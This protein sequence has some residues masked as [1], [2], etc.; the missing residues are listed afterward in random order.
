MKKTDAVT[1]RKKY[2]WE[3]KQGRAS[4]NC[5]RCLGSENYPFNGLAFSRKINR[6]NS[7]THTVSI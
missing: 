5:F 4:T 2:C 3:K 1:C 6:F 7:D